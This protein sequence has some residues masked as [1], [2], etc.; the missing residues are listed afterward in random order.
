MSALLDAPAIRRGTTWQRVRVRLIAAGAGLIGRLPEQLCLRFADLA[1]DLAY[2]LARQRRRQAEANLGRV[3]A[4]AAAHGTGSASA[5]AA[6]ADRQALDALVRSAFRHHARYWV[7]LIRAPRMTAAYI[8]ARVDMEDADVLAAALAP[9]GPIIFVGL[10]FG[11]IELPGFY[12]AQVAGRRAVGPMET[13]GDPEL[14]RWFIATRGTMGLRL[15]GLREAR[16][17]LVAALK[18]GEAVGIVA[19]RDLTGGGIPIP[20]FGHQAPLPAGP[21]LLVLE[22]EAPTLVIGVRRT[23]LGRYAARI[24]PAPLPPAG[25]RRTRVEAFLATS[26][27]IFEAIVSEA[28]EQWWAVFYPIWPDLSPDRSGIAT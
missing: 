12:L 19:D 25:D 16:R 13:V 23:G 7:E 6:A 15:V 2:R 24:V 1:G 22:T 26:A 10:H 17:A 11:A 4:W 8:R 21:A 28:P 18:A 20:L 9:G 3:A 27:A 5:R 14:Q